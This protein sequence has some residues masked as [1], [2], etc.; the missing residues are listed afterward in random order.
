MLRRAVDQFDVSLDGRHRAGY[1]AVRGAPPFTQVSA[2]S[3]RIR[4]RVGKAGPALATIG[5]RAIRERVRR[6]PAN[7]R[8]LLN[9]LWTDPAE[10]DRA[11]WRFGQ[12]FGYGD[13]ET[14]IVGDLMIPGAFS[15]DELEW[16]ADW[17]AP[18]AK[19]RS[20][21]AIARS[22]FEHGPIFDA[23]SFTCWSPRKSGLFI[24]Y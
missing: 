4:A 6:E 1:D 19:P 17:Q 18:G 16:F 23:Y 5:M 24:R 21:R 8:P 15:L 22:C 14:E 7:I 10:L 20:G 13:D 12:E 2:D 3:S 11:A 9:H